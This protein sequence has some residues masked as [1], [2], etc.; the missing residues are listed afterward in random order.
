MTLWL[1]IMNAAGVICGAYLH[2]AW[3][4]GVAEI[5]YAVAVGMLAGTAYASLFSGMSSSASNPPR[6]NPP[7]EGYWGE[8]DQQ[9][10]PP[11][12]T[13]GTRLT[14]LKQQRPGD[15]KR[16]IG[17]PPSPQPRS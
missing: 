4:S 5:T 13:E 2:V 11:P 14:L 7:R 10:P 3:M 8:T 9:R 1:W 15:R 16:P 12:L 17:P 6:S